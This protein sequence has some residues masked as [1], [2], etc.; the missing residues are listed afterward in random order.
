MQI[1]CIPSS[2]SWKIQWG[3]S[4]G[5]LKIKSLERTWPKLFS[6]ENLVNFQKNVNMGVK[7]QM[8]FSR[9]ILPR[10][11]SFFLAPR[12]PPN[13]FLTRNPIVQSEFR[14]NKSPRS[15]EYFEKKYK[16]AYISI[17]NEVSEPW[18][19]SIVILLPG[20]SYE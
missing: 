10:K 14:K 8:H 12:T 1:L 9:W 6:F 19:S 7:L 16:F 11:R 17:T 13:G 20:L 4:R 18:N 5:G 3:Y 2:S 15:Y